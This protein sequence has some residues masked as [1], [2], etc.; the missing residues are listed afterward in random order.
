[1]YRKVK[2]RLTSCKQLVILR[3][4]VEEREWEMES[5]MR[6]KTREKVVYATAV[7]RSQLKQ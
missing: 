6:K 2:G 4:S 5:G 1:M 3:D 7:S